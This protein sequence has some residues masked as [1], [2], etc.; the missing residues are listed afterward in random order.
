M[1]IMYVKY[2]NGKRYSTIKEGENIIMTNSKIIPFDSINKV[3]ENK[4]TPYFNNIQH[5][6]DSMSSDKI[7]EEITNFFFDA[8]HKNYLLNRK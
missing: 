1:E 4:N 8:I 7:N 3:K 5:K 2:V 6:N